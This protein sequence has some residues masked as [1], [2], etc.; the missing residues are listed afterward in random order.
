MGYQAIDSLFYLED[1]A[2][3]CQTRINRTAARHRLPKTTRT[4]V[5]YRLPKTNRTVVRHRMQKT[6]R[7]AARHRLPASELSAFG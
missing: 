2:A 3:L 6:T 1:Y 7:T 5:R 4:V